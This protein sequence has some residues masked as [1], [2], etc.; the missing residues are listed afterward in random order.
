MKLQVELS[1]YTKV[2]EVVEITYVG[3]E[4]IGGNEAA[5]FIGTD[6]ADTLKQLQGGSFVIVKA[7]LPSTFKTDRKTLRYH[8]GMPAGTEVKIQSKPFLVS[9]L[10]VLEKYLPNAD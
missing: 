7:R 3:T 1:G 6:L 10:P 8:H 2:R 5:R 9:L 4:V